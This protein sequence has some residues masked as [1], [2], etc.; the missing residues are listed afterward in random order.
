[1]SDPLP[2]D[3]AFDTKRCPGC[4]QV[5]PRREFHRR[6]QSKDGLQ[7]LCRD[8]NIEQ[9]K[10]FHR[11]NGE[12]CRNRIRG[13][14]SAL[15]DAGRRRLLEYLLEH[16]CVDC[17][18]SDPVVLEFDHLRD[19]VANVSALVNRLLPCE[20]ILAEIEKC[21]VVCANCHRRRTGARLGSFRVREYAAMMRATAPSPHEDGAP[22]VPL[23]GV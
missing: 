9:A 2:L 15:R 19:K 10:R 4:R 12:H 1:M 17:G 13:R 11:E 6:R 7:R 21:E 23:E 16:P 3:A 22:N 5:K 20:V 18:E 8:C 14:A